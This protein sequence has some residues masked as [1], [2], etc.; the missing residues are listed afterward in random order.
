MVDEEDEE[1]V[2]IM[3]QNHRDM[4]RPFWVPLGTLS[5]TYTQFW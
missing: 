1:G 3:S 2:S 4:D 5:L